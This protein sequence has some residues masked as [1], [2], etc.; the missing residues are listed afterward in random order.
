MTPQWIILRE[1][2]PLHVGSVFG[3]IIETMGLPFPANFGEDLVYIARWLQEHSRKEPQ[4][5]DK[6]VLSDSFVLVVQETGLKVF[7][8]RE[9]R[10]RM[11]LFNFKFSLEEVRENLLKQFPNLRSMLFFDLRNDGYTF[12]LKCLKF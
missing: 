11:N 12:D 1:K 5:G 3:T 7:T 6:P 9:A 8:R 2:E 10:D 4:A